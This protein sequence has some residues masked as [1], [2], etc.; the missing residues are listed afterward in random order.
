MGNSRSKS[1]GD[2]DCGWVK[3]YKE[4]KTNHDEA[5]R[6]IDCAITLEEEE[7][8]NEVIIR[9]FHFQYFINLHNLD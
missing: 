1:D 5:Y 9:K 4:I 3:T 8:N 6:C 7:R 2:E